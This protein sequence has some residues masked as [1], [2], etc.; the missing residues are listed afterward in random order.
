MNHLR[1]TSDGTWEVRLVVPLDARAAIGRNNLTKR[2]GRVSPSEANRLAVAIVA[3][4]QAR[5]AAARISPAQRRMAAERQEESLRVMMAEKL[6]GWEAA[7]DT[8]MDT[9]MET[10]LQPQESLLGLYEDYA[11]ERE[12]APATRKRWR[13]VIDHLIAHLGHDNAAAVTPK[14]ILEWKVVLLRDRSQRTVREVYLAAVKA[15]YGWGIENQKVKENPA[16]GIKVRVPPKVK[17]RETGFTPDEA[18]MIL[19]EAL[20]RDHSRVSPHY[21]RARRW[22]PWLCAYSG[23]RVGEIAQMRG[24]DVKEISG[25]HVMNITPEAG[26][27]KTAKARLVP[28]HPHLI[29]M[30]FVEFVRRA[31]EGALFYNPVRSRNGNAA[32]PQFKKAGE[33]IAKWVRAIGVNDKEIQPNH[34]WRHLFKSRAR[35]ADIAEGVSDAITG[36]ATRT[37][38]EAYGEWGVEALARA[39]DKFPRY[40]IE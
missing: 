22:I 18:K 13:P 3:E 9:A 7:I 23:A 5:I 27:T 24:C 29:E 26:S 11:K 32:N 4:F 10:A 30:G 1:K 33:H 37:E 25:F 8:A 17:T 39:M 28:V 36:H 12:L 21:Q 31:G 35:N 15:V 14:N 40:N 34:A 6:R 38:G 20:H 2:L 16:T 19:R